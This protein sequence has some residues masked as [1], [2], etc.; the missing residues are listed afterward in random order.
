MKLIL[1]DDDAN[2]NAVFCGM[3]S[4]IDGYD[5]E[6]VP[7]CMKTLLP[8]TFAITTPRSPP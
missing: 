6:I 3:T 4:V 5:A 2:F 8:N 7:F 1:L